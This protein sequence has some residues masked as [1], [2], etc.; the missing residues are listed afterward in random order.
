MNKEQIR[1]TALSRVV[2]IE[3]RFADYVP[4]EVQHYYLLQ[5]LLA[6]GVDRYLSVHGLYPLDKHACNEGKDLAGY[7]GLSPFERNCIEF[8]SETIDKE[9][10]AYERRKQIGIVA[11]R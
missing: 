1:Q 5:Y 8:L 3:D 10:R 9:E 4:P 6:Y 7:G 2:S 11:S